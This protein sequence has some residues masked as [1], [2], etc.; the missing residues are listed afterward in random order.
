MSII[1]GLG[2]VLFSSYFIVKGSNAALKPNDFVEEAEPVADK[3]VPMLQRTLPSVGGYIPDDTRA[4]VRATG[5]AQAAGGLAMATGLGRRLGASVVAA[6]MVPHVIASVPDKTLP[7]AERAAGRSVLLRNVSLLGASL[8]A[9]KDTAG[10]PG[11]AW[12]TAN[13]K[14]RL[15]SSA[16]DQK[17]S[18][19]AN[20][21][22]MSRKARKRIAKAEK[23]ARKTA[24]K[25]QKKAAARS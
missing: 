3:L 22:K 8:M 12:R 2:R 9:S 1:R 11:L 10:R 19:A 6:T 13:T 25:M 18:L 4:L 21:D 16:R 23:K 7:K 24:E 15:E 14:H 17:A 5:A 20:Q